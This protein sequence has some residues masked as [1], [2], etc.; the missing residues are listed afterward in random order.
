M[1]SKTTSKETVSVS[2]NGRTQVVAYKGEPDQLTQIIAIVR[3][4]EIIANHPYVILKHKEVPN[5][6]LNAKGI[7][8]AASENIEREV[9]G[10]SNYSSEKYGIHKGQT[11]VVREPDTFNVQWGENIITACD[12]RDVMIKL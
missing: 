2:A 10:V 3:K 1:L 5:L 11:V 4:D 12:D 6:V 7:L 8:A 9:V